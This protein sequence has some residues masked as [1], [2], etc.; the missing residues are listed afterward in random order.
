MDVTS[1][2][3]LFDFI[4]SLGKEEEEEE[5][6]Y[7]TTTATAT[8]ITAVHNN[9]NIIDTAISDVDSTAASTAAS[10]AGSVISDQDLTERGDD[11]W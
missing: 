10:T 4:E 11:V 2:R 7:S 9:T 5:E 3:D 6:K 1:D 8:T